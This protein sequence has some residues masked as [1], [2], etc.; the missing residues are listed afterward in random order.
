MGSFCL[1]NRHGTPHRPLELRRSGTVVET[2]EHLEGAPIGREALH[3]LHELPRPILLALSL[4][5]VLLTL[6]AVPVVLSVLAAA[7]GTGLALLDVAEVTR[8]S[9]EEP[10]AERKLAAELRHDK[11][12]IHGHGFTSNFFNVQALD[13]QGKECSFKGTHKPVYRAVPSPFTSSL[14]G[15]EST[16]DQYGKVACVGSLWHPYSDKAMH[17]V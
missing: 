4:E 10:I 13:P 16:C 17:F 14:C 8:R 5:H 6:L 7:L 3:V 15:R 2:R 9:R 12:V 11:P 1:L